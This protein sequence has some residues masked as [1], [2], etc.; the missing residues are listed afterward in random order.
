MESDI[1]L[2]AREAIRLVEV[3]PRQAAE[4]AAQAADD[5]RRAHDRAAAAV[6]ARARGLAAFYLRDLDAATSHLQR[7]IRF[8]KIAKSPTLVGEARMSLA[9]V[10]AWR[11]RSQAALRNVDAALAELAG[12]ERARARAQRG[13]ILH[14]A[15]RHDEALLDYRAALPAL[16]RAQDHQWVQRVLVNRGNILIHRRAFGAAAADLR[17]AQ[18][19]SEMYGLAMSE[20]IALH[21]LG[22]LETYRGNVPEALQYLDQ[23]ESRYL[24]LGAAR[25]PLL[26]DRS[27]LL[28]SALLID[29]ARQTAESAVLACQQEGRDGALPEARLLLARAARLQGDLASANI[30]ARTAAAEFSRNHQAAWAALSQ[31]I[32]VAVQSEAASCWPSGPG[33][34]AAIDASRGLWPDVTLDALITVAQSAAAAGR[35]G[36]ASAL[37]LRASRS[38]RRGPAIVRSRAWYAEALHRHSAGRDREAVTAIRAGLRILDE[39]AS[40]FN[41]SDLRAHVAGHRIEL[42]QLGLRI[43]VEAGD[44]RRVFEWSERGRASNLRRLPARPPEDAEFAAS[45]RELRMVLRRLDE[46]ASS[47]RLATTLGQRQ[48]KLERDIRDHQR[49]LHGAPR[50]TGTTASLQAIAGALDDRVLVEYIQLDGTLHAVC[51]AGGRL[52]LHGI[53]EVDTVAGL[54]EQLRFA[55]RRLGRRSTSSASTFAA[56]K[57]I[58][59]AATALDEI[60]LRPL[61]KVADRSMVL[62]PTGVL[63]SL[64]WSILP[65]CYGR[66]LAVAPS[67]ELWHRAQARMPAGG[68]A[69]VAAGPGLPGARLEAEAVAELYQVKPLIGSEATIEAVRGSLNDAA[70]AH[71]AAHGRVRADNPLFGSLRFADGPLMIY[72]LERLERAPHTVVVAACDAGRPIVPVGDELLGLTIALLSQ[73]TRQLIASSV[74]V[75]DTETAPFMLNLHRLM[76][77]GHPA[78][79]A[80]AMAQQKYGS[81]GPLELA[82]AASFQCFGAGY[83]A[84]IVA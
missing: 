7:A 61:A 78:A 74:P 58:R 22:W 6:A 70:V 83:L 10:Q 80:L 43:A 71:L 33:L 17:R 59:T 76:A 63:Q 67:A 77:S 69:L 62:V 72:D 56:V 4:L 2:G 37:L 1:C 48:S 60:L 35:P 16:R 3:S 55:L 12:L 28:L 49:R 42:A 39:Q 38:R 34:E 64:P 50:P 11:G 68:H 27:Q 21:N 8:G 65:S 5:A 13:S 31:V 57:L 45:L 30:Q 14:L 81:I 25:G 75:L 54:N 51:L 18:Q 73:G 41:A 47:P 32:A 66:P 19:I 23:A 36:Q 24:E 9:F 40:S 84:P 20:G 52:S 53:G 15:G 79:E 44:P 26:C 29:E 82:T 46:A